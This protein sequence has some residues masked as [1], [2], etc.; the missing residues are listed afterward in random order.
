MVVPNRNNKTNGDGGRGHTREDGWRHVCACAH[1]AH[2]WL[3][4]SGFY[5]KQRFETLAFICTGRLENHHMCLND[6]GLADNHVHQVRLTAVSG[7]GNFEGV[8]RDQ[9][10][11]HT[12]WAQST[13][14]PAPLLPA[15]FPQGS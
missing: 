15:I 13:L 14:C 8:Y 11:W 6:G 4:R 1:V 2:P 10:T 9:I 5:G 7:K 12:V 3:Q